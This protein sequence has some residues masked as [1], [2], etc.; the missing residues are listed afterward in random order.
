MP[1][2]IQQAVDALYRIAVIEG[3]AQSPARLNLLADFCVEQ[4]ARRGLAGAGKEIEIPGVGRPKKWDVGWL[5]DG[6]VRL[7]ISLKSLLK[8]MP[9]MVP[10][11]IDDLMGEMANVQLHSPEIVVGYVMIFN[12]GQDTRSQKHG[13]TW[14]EVFR[15]FVNDLSGRSPPFWAP[16]TV[17]AHAVAE[18]NFDIDSKLRSSPDEFDEFFDILV[19]RVKERNPGVA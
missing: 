1:V 12:S 2:T 19:N 4:L 15:G 6:K 14:L 9:G 13:K 18:V 16:G 3:K 11:R 10:N 17:E 8:N 5:Y 7:G